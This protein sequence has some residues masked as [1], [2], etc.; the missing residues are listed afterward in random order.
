MK[1]RRIAAVTTSRAD[2]GHLY[3]P[4]RDLSSKPEVDLRILALGPHLSPEFRLTIN[5]IARDGFT[6]EEGIE[7]LLSSD[8]DIGM[9]KTIGLAALSL[10]DILG[11]LRPDLLLLLTCW[12]AT[13][14]AASWKRP[15]S[16][17]LRS[18]SGGGSRAASM[19]AMFSTQ[20][21]P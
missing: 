1:K 10:A 20:P 14:A 13:P 12:W 18:I 16:K 17:S 21:L 3:W 11:R 19:G 5:E 8:T 4:L 2:Y 7:C 6:V 15:R 9:A